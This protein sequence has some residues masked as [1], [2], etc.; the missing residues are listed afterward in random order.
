V[1]FRGPAPCREPR[2]PGQVQLRSRLQPDSLVVSH[3]L[4]LKKNQSPNRS[5]SCLY[6]RPPRDMEAGSEAL[7][8]FAQRGGGCSIPGDIQVRLE[9][10]LSNLM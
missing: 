3:C 4:F 5:Q 9:E 7:E 10:V 6:V 8:Q 2:S 1:L